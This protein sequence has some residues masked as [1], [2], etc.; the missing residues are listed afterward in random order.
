MADLTYLSF[1]AGVQSSALLAMSALVNG[2]CPQADV[3]IFAD[4]Q[5]EPP[6]VYKQFD[7][8]QEWAKR[9]G[10]PV[11]RVTIGCLSQHVKERHSGERARFAA[12]PVFTMGADGRAAPLRRQCTREYKIEPIQR[13]VK[14][15]LGVKK[16]QRMKFKVES[17]IG[18]SL[19]EASRMGDSREHWVTNRYPLVDAR[20]NRHHC[21]T[22][23]EELGLPVPLKSSCLYCP[24]HS[25]RYW[26]MLKKDHPAEFQKAVVFDATIRNMSK[27]GVREPVFIHRAL[28]PLDKIEF[29]DQ[30]SLFDEECNGVCGV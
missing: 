22:M 24:Y 4:T 14:E 29:G 8:M 5:D 7:V 26:R 9:Y 28:Q 30:P 3:A 6:W 21:I 19:D 12:I 20:M 23:L 27:S 13:R 25:D 10:I 1:G 15:I 11:E 16:R 2:G 17:L 18:I